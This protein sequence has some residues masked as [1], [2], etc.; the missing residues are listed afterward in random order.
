ME[1]IDDAF[2]SR[3]HF[4]FEYKDLDSPTMVGIWKNFL[5]KEISRPGG[6]INEADLE[7]LAKG[8]MLSG[9]EIKN[10]ASC[11]KAISRVRKQEL[12]L[13]LVKDTIEKL[14]YAPEARRI[15]S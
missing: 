15:E 10:A 8:Y 6:H 13:A 14:G 9:R 11:A 5:A 7:Q 3:L 12:S 2:M 4:K 1:D